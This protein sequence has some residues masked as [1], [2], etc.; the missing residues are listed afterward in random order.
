M[1][2]QLL[3]MSLEM[4]PTGFH[5]PLLELFIFCF[6]AYFET[7]LLHHLGF[8]FLT[9]TE[10]ACVHITMDG[11][12]GNRIHLRYQQSGEGSKF[13]GLPP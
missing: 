6:G 2:L 3:S 1:S 12:H 4:L 13:I 7:T 11:A 5:A 10:K 8:A 9:E